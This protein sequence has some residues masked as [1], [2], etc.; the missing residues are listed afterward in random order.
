VNNRVNSAIRYVS[1]VQQY[2]VDD[3]WTMP[4]ASGGSAAG[5]CKD[6][7][8]EKRRALIAAGVPAQ[9]L[10]IAI[11]KTGWGESHAVLLVA[12]NKGELVLD[13][14]RGEILPWRQAPYTWVERQAPGSSLS[15]VKIVT[16]HQ[17]PRSFFPI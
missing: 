14:L 4:L 10:S 7:V 13:S 2:G 15:W 11:V 8:L 16:D 6:Y 5:D 12:T 9:D 3:Y 1:D 17:A